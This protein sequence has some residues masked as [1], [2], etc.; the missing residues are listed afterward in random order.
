MR[1]YRPIKSLLIYT[2]NLM[3]TQ[4]N[5]AALRWP[6][7]VSTKFIY[8]LLTLVSLMNAMRAEL[9][10]RLAY[11][12]G[13]NPKPHLIKVFPRSFFS[14]LM[15]EILIQ[16]LGSALQEQTKTKAIFSCK[17]QI[18]Q[19]LDHA[20]EWVLE[21]LRI[22]CRYIFCLLTKIRVLKSQWWNYQEHC[23]CFSLT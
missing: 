5:C 18:F 9:S 19:I 6:I 3:I 17:W 12:N 10:F 11:L 23:S 14:N 21:G 22:L 13:F 20:F 16:Y 15:R 2:R 1:F 4:E 8:F 7:A